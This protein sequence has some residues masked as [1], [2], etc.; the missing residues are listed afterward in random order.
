MKKNQK[1][2]TCNRLHLDTGILTD[3]A[4]KSP[5]ILMMSYPKRNRAGDEGNSTL[6]PTN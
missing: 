2:P 4:Q 3:Y 1:I 5:Q 6:Q